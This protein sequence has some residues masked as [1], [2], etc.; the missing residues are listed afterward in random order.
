MRI[1]LIKSAT[2]PDYLQD[3]GMHEFTYALLPHGGDFVD[4]KTVQEAVTLNDP[5]YV[6]NGVCT[7]SYESFLSFDNDQIELDAVKKSEDGKYI[8]VRFHDFAG[9][10]QKVTVTPGF[11]WRSWREGDLRE[12]AIEE[13]HLDGKITL[14]L[15]AYE[16]KTI[17]ILV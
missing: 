17:L 6:S 13:A 4:A 5:L 11:T 15:H 16:I 3:Q 2:H 9:S 7:V 14:S 1:T 8:V 10:S 12:R